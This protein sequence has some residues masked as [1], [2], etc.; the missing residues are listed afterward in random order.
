MN[1]QLHRGYPRVRAVHLKEVPSLKKDDVAG[2]GLLDFI[3]AG[4]M[5]LGVSHEN[6]MLFCVLLRE[7]FRLN[8]LFS[9]FFRRSFQRP[10][11]HDLPIL[12]GEES[13]LLN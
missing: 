5:R 11:L 8:R 13:I 6:A 12:R 7:G 2:V 3:I 4:K 10:A 1:I 9:G